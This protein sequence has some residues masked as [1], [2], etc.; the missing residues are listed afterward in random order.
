LNRLQSCFLIKAEQ[1]AREGEFLTET[2][3]PPTPKVE[4]PDPDLMSLEDLDKVIA[5]ADP[6]ALENIEGV[7]RIAEEEGILE[8]PDADSLVDADAKNMDGLKAKLKLKAILFWVWLKSMIIENAKQFVVWLSE[9]KTQAVE[10]KGKFRHW[11]IK[12]KLLFFGGIFLFMGALA[13][14]YFAFVK[15]SLVYKQELFITSFEPLADHKWDISEEN[16]ME[17][18]YNSSRI[19]KNI[20]LLKK[21]VVNIQPS[22]SSGPN[23]MV[24]F[25]FSLEGNSSEVLLEIKD[26]EGE[27]LDQVQRTIEAF[28]FDEL[29]DFEGKK[30]VSEKVR[31]TINGLLT[32]GK[33]RKVY[34]QGIILKP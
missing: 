15:K 31:A 22:S 17:T 25:E 6:N 34:I 10:A 2:K 26:R 29:N 18:F 33:L 14:A 28:T 20:F 12:S 19:P 9:K 27:I 11:P 30:I 4:V 5:A 24:A 8:I 16:S 3:A 1:T 21:I 23:P 7:R 32:L 13:V